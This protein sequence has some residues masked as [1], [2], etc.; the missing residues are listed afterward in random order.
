MR[1]GGEEDPSRLSSRPHSTRDRKR[2]HR[3][4]HVSKI[5]SKS[6]VPFSPWALPMF[7]GGGGEKILGWG[8]D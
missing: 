8:G 7:P 4:D 5:S 6:D 2:G 1:V 3:S